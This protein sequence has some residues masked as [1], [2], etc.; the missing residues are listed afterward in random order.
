MGSLCSPNGKEKKKGLHED[1]GENWDKAD[2]A[3]TADVEVV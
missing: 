1:L 2:N 3:S